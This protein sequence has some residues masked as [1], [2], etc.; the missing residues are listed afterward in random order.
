MSELIQVQEEDEH[1]IR[2]YKFVAEL[3]D[4]ADAQGIRNVDKSSYGNQFAFRNAGVYKVKH[5]P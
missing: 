4:C 1:S 3:G 2:P 5:A